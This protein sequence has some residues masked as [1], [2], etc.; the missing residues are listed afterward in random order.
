MKVK[1]KQLQRKTIKLTA[2]DV[3]KALVY[4]L[5]N[6]D[7]GYEKEDKE[8]K[9]T[10][11]KKNKHGMILMGNNTSVEFDENGDVTITTYYGD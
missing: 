2:K 3:K 6:A 4:Y 7:Y 5:E 11:V 1:D 10:E 9:I 8:G